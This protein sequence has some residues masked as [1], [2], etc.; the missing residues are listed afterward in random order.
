M[1]SRRINLLSALVAALMA[2]IITA[3]LWLNYQKECQGQAR[4]LIVRGRTILSALESSLRSHR[5][6]GGMFEQNVQS[7]VEESA[8]NSG[9]IGLGIYN[10]DGHVLAHGGKLPER[11]TLKAEPQWTSG[12]LVMAQQTQI[13][14]PGDS[15]SGPPGF[16]WGRGR[17]LS[18]ASRAAYQGPIWLAVLLDDAEYHQSLAK[19]RWRFA[20]SLLGALAVLALGL[21]M[22]VMMQRQ[23]RLR[24]ELNLA[25]ER[26]KRLEELAQLGAGLAHETKNP[27]SLIRGL[28]QQWLARP[29]AE[30]GLR[31]EAQQIVNESD[32]VV[33]RI[34]SFLAYSRL[35][36]PRVQSLDLASV[37]GEMM[38][39]F[40]DEAKSKGVTL[41]L[42]AAPAQIMADP[43][44]L[45]QIVVNLLANALAFCRPDDTVEIS[46]APDQSDDSGK[47]VLCIRDS[48][49]GIAPEDL[50]QVTR[51]YF[52]RRPGGTGLGLAIVKQ[53]SDAHGW[54]LEIQSAAGQGATAR[55]A[56]LCQAG[57]HQT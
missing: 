22:I 51:P 40:Q 35:P 47:M 41:K 7:L 30:N 5:H 43:D 45:R 2:G 10:R 37:L 55:I 18:E 20:L 29:D 24:A 31:R 1:F 19:E 57:G 32:R 33:G 23:G 13:Q 53:I 8:R 4:V 49:P 34:N 16:G 26:E 25:A 15:Q 9:I 28:A 39:I 36:E 12:G 27:L 3:G 54:R 17:Q 50:P 52:T 11:L 6:M 48:G 42:T 38:R 46:L 56:G 14:Q 44:M 21:S